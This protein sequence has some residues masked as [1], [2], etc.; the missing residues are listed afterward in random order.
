M[1]CLLTL[2]DLYRINR[3][4]IKKNEAEFHSLYVLL[5]LGCKIPKMVGLW[6][7]GS[8]CFSAAC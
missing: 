2:F 7:S 4:S 3:K 8:Y 6:L 1:K 5:H